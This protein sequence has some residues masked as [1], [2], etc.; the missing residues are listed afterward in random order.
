MSFRRKRGPEAG[1]PS[2][3]PMVDRLGKEEIQE[4]TPG[5][6]LVYETTGDEQTAGLRR[7]EKAR[8][9]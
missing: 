2:K 9:E 3:D 5:D 4:V 6:P 7:S 1:C 8:E